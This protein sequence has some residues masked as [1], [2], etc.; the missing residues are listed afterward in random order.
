[1]A[2]TVPPLDTPS[3]EVLPEAESPTDAGAPGIVPSSG[4]SQQD[5]SAQ[6]K[7]CITQGKRYLTM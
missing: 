7:D 3:K 5:L 6:V 4:N 1:M 2:I